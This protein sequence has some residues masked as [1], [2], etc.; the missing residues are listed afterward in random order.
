[1][2][3]NYSS[4]AILGLLVSGILLL[5]SCATAPK[6]PAS[7]AR[8][9]FSYTKK[10][11]SWFIPREMSR[12]D[13]PGLS[14]AL[15]GDQGMLWS[16]GF[17][18]A[19]V[20]RRIPATD[21]TIYGI[22][23]VTKLFTAIG[24]MQA[25]EQGRI[26]LDAPLSAYVPE[27]SMR[28][29]FASAAPITPR[30]LLTHHAGLPG[31]FLK[32]MWTL[33]PIPFA[34]IL[35]RL[36]DEYV[37]YPP[38]QVY[39]YSNLGYS[40][41][42][43]ILEKTSGQDYVS[44]MNRSVL[45]PLGMTHSSFAIDPDRQRQFAVG[46]RQG[47]PGAEKYFLRDVPAG[48]LFSSATDM[49]RFIH[50]LLADGRIGTNILLRPDTLREMWREQNGDVPLDMDMRVGLGWMLG[51][52]DLDYA[53]AVVHH[54]GGTLGSVSELI[55]LPEHKLGVIVLA[56]SAAGSAA[57]TRIA[58]QTLKLA[59]EAKT[60]ITEPAPPKP[61]ERAR[62]RVSHDA[63][64]RLAGNYASNF[65]A[66]FPVEN[67]G[68]FLQTV[69]QGKTFALLPRAHARFEAQYRL[70]GWLPFE[71]PALRQVSFSAQHIAGRDVIAAHFKGKRYLAGV[72]IASHDL[73]QA[74]L[75]RIG[76]YAIANRGEDGTLVENLQ[77]AY[78]HG[79]LMLKYTLPEAPG[80]TPSIAL[81]PVD[82]HEAISPGLG[83][84]R[85]ETFRVI[86][87]QGEQRLLYSG[88]ELRRVSKIEE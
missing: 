57:L 16:Q 19:D 40:L 13:V 11:L 8:S 59:L 82:D 51:Q 64:S 33:R 85:G 70:F 75:Q 1:M 38:N 41:L 5:T 67:K 87:V 52:A 79:V 6:K 23:S 72:P 73:P 74:W 76:R 15:I 84:F 48:A 49:G 80:F 31:D 45:A 37:S 54:N 36:K 26:V 17:G 61:V 44:Y 86:T 10:Y 3:M 66:V 28:S 29:R 53:G 77:L 12:A 27:F 63:L 71:I 24:I 2:R 65:G 43:R 9:D 58:V 35:P 69:F 83:R 62:V 34:Q 39:S 42:G 30:N 32:G 14:I 68:T 21:Q 22:G 50:A 81:V 25:V 7:L 55:L 78:E 4:R 46:Y 56:N 60:G 18:Y 88:Y 47:R 20:E